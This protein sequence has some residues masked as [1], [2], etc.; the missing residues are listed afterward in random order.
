VEADE[1]FV[2][3]LLNFLVLPV[4]AVVKLTADCKVPQIG[5]VSN[6]HQSLKDNIPD[7]A[8]QKDFKHGFLYPLAEDNTC[9]A[10]LR[11]LALVVH[12]GYKNVMIKYPVDIPDFRRYSTFIL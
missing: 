5:A 11:N 10:L 7:M 9:S 4:A 1:R 8:M 2:S 3:V 12:S 6:I